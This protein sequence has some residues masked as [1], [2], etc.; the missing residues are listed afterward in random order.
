MT[1]VIFFDKM[2]IKHLTS[3]INDL[4][5]DIYTSN[6]FRMENISNLQDL[7]SEDVI[8]AMAIN[9]PSICKQNEFLKLPERTLEAVLSSDSI[10]YPDPLTLA[11]FFIEIFNRGDGIAQYFC[12]LIPIDQMDS[13]SVQMISEKL[14]SMDLVQES[15]RFVR[16]HSLYQTLES[17]Q[18]QIDK[19]NKLIESASKN[20]ESFS[21][22]VEQSTELLK[23]QTQM[24]NN[25]KAQVDDLIEQN[26]EAQKKFDE[27]KQKILSSRKKKN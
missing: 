12:D 27:V 14:L 13:K 4:T 21:A 22:R 6:I 5:F 11:S 16:I 23:K 18:A 15:N 7:K 19:T 9:F 1:Y 24:Y 26:K 10:K 3:K 2:K 8:N 25:T 17:K 20:L